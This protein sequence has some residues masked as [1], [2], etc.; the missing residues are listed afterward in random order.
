MIW[1]MSGKIQ[2]HYITYNYFNPV[3]LQASI[4]VGEDILPTAHFM[5]C[6]SL[7]FPILFTNWPQ[8][9]HELLPTSP[10]KVSSTVSAKIS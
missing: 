4:D 9:A 8:K 1:I 6:F 5:F 7:E 2:C 10:L 3:Y